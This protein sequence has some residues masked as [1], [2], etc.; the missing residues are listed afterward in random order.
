MKLM[1]NSIYGKTVQ[2]MERFRNTTVNF[3]E[4][5]KVA[6]QGEHGQLRWSSRTGR[7]EATGAAQPRAGGVEDFRAG[8]PHDVEVPQQVASLPRYGLL[9]CS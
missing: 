9:H 2:S 6:G 4:V 1:L 3:D 5:A 8:L 7:Q